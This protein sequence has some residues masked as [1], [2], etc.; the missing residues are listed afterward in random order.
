MRTWDDIIRSARIA[1][2]ESGTAFFTPENM[3]LSA[4]RVQQRIFRASKCSQTTHTFTTTPAESGEVAEYELPA[5]FLETLAVRVDDRPITQSL[6]RPNIYFFPEGTPLE[7]WIENSGGS[8][9]IGF[10]PTP[11]T[12]LSAIVRYARLSPS[13][14]L[15]VWVLENT[16]VTAATVSVDEVGVNVV[17]TGGDNAGTHTL[18]FED[19]ATMQDMIDGL[20]RIGAINLP[21]LTYDSDES[22]YRGR[23]VIF[24]VGEQ[25]YN[26]YAKGAVSGD[27]TMA[28]IAAGY[29]AFD[30]ALPIAV[31]DGYAYIYETDTDMGFGGT[32]DVDAILWHRT[33]D[34]ED[35]YQT[36]LTIAADDVKNSLLALFS[37]TTE[38]I[39]KLP[40]VF[41]ADAGGK[42]Y[43]ANFDD[44]I[45]NALLWDSDISSWVAWSTWQTP[46]DTIAL[47]GDD[48]AGGAFDTPG[49]AVKAKLAGDIVDT[50][51]SSIL[52]E[53]SAVSAL[54]EQNR[55]YLFT[56]PECPP[57]SMDVLETG[58]VE[59][60]KFADREI[61]A[62]AY[63]NA[64]FEGLLKDLE[65]KWKMKQFSDR[66]PSFGGGRGSNQDWF[67]VI[68][69]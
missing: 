2:G 38:K 39:I 26:Q 17:I 36:L 25:P 57:E 8:Q 20:R 64:K 46:R 52:E 10:T 40:V 41:E 55:R 29:G 33:I 23:A 4:H 47:W 6:E 65:K 31:E 62:S 34:G 69:P 22:I 12:A 42:D 19:Y 48:G 9:K 18:L 30:S 15:T 28:Y 60:M 32:T 3:K 66:F 24:Q 14:G 49:V 68:V 43:V 53:L 56:A 51:D 13:Y 35:V 61:E 37:A 67:Q 16:G 54:G 5:D 11:S 63:K 58:I 59:A 45:S 27:D 44:A 7:Y 50:R 1:L 21:E